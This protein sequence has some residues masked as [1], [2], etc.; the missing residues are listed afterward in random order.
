MGCHRVHKV[1]YWCDRCGYICAQPTSIGV[2]KQHTL[3]STITL[4][5]SLFAEKHL[6]DECLIVAMKYIGGWDM[7]A[8]R[9]FMDSLLAEEPKR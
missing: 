2:A 4:N 5:A 8:P 3:F 1:T 7:G 6:C 9:A